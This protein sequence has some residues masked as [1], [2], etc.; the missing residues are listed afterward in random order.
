[1][2]NYILTM[3]CVSGDNVQVAIHRYED[4][5]RWLKTLDHEGSN[6]SV[7][8]HVWDGEQT[9]V[10]DTINLTDQ[11]VGEYENG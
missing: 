8:K 9:A 6:W 1:M 11:I 4:I 10:I 5:R 3:Y 2:G 7:V